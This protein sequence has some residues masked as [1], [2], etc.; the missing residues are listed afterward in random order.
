[1]GEQDEKWNYAP[2]KP[3]H[4]ILVRGCLPPTYS[5]LSFRIVAPPGE[6]SAVIAAKIVTV[7]QALIS[8]TDAN[9]NVEIWHTRRDSR[10]THALLV[11]ALPGREETLANGKRC[12]HF[13]FRLPSHETPEIVAHIRSFLGLEDIA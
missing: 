4:K 5:G 3:T 13:S 2:R 8:E 12:T 10:R 6:D 11:H 1:M 7:L 9:K